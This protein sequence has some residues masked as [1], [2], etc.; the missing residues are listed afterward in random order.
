MFTADWPLSLVIAEWVFKL[1]VIG[2]L[3]LRRRASSPTTLAWIIVIF[4]LPLFGMILYLLFYIF[5]IDHSGRRVAE[6]LMRAAQR[7]V[8]C[9]VLIDAVGSKIFARSD[10]RRNMASAG[11]RIVEALKVHPLR[12]LFAR[13]DLRNHRKIAVID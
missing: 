8:E 12:M 3:L 2:L 1:V 6:A 13:I 11:V 7:G 4:A 5:L 10:L 9:R